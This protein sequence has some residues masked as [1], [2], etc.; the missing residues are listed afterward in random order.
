MSVPAAARRRVAELHSELHEHNY[1]YYVLDDPVISDA[2]Y[3][4]LLRE[5]QDLEA[6]YPELVTADSPTQRVG[7][8]PSKAFDEVKHA[9]R[10]LSLDNAFSD[11]ELGDFDRRV[12]E[13]LG[14][15]MVEYAAEPKLD[16]VA[17]S[18]RYEE[19][20]L[21]RAATRGDGVTGED[22]TA[23]VRTIAGVPLRLE[24]RGIPLVLEVRGEIYLSHRGFAQLNR[25]ALEQ[26]HKSFV[27]PRNAAAG[28]LRQLDPKVTASRPLEIYC[29]GIGQVEGGRLPE[30]HTDILAQLRDWRLRIYDG[31]ERV[32]GLDG[33]I[34]YY[35]A[36]GE[37][38]DSL[39]FD[40]DGVVFKVDR[41]DQQEVLGFVARAPR[42]AIARKFPAQEEQTR[43]LGIDVQVGRTGALTPVARLEPVFV[44]G[45]TVTNATLHNADEVQRKDVRSGDTVI[46]R[47]AGDVIPEVVSVIRE[48]RVKGARRFIMPVICPKCGSAV[49]R[50]EGEAVA[51][52]SGGLF[53]PAQRKQ[54]I[55]HFA[56]RRAMD[57]DGLGDK[58]V[59]QLVERGLISDVSDLYRLTVDD[60]AGLERMAEKSAGNLV[61]ALEKSKHT[62][63][64]RFVYALGIRE[65]GEAT[66]RVLAQ[67]FGDLEPL[68]QADADALQGVRDVGPVVAQHIVGFFAEAHNREVIRKLVTAGVHWQ[69]VELPQEQPLTGKTFVITGTLSM[70]RSEL[71]VRLLA[72]GAKVEGSV[73]KKTDYVVAGENAGSKLDKAGELGVTVLTEADCLAML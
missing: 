11:E 49:E 46:I 25:Q 72:A 33:C 19:G 38:R 55:K 40:I 32:A 66:A 70:P 51:R 58:L 26:G 20:V 41:L 8:T 28:S 9:V 36:L 18:M 61:R 1:R 69:A 50:V 16:G 34:A 53:C 6:K 15:G 62:T 52:C 42:W 35:D 10:M 48:K 59:D 47:R 31:I 30:S 27:N 5:L 37:V 44:G 12:R 56:S 24:G 29:Y 13:R 65:V 60:I 45:V 23:N 21:V 22:I 64:E 7:A 67:S 68:M 57:V 3:D 54:A 2:G 17:V 39:P 73:S 4:R 71:K 43:V 14:V 63:L